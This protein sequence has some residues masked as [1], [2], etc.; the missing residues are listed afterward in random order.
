MTWEDSA[1][2]EYY[3]KIS[4]KF[5]KETADYLTFMEQRHKVATLDY[6]AKIEHDNKMKDSRIAHLEKILKENNIKE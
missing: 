2:K 6:I 1:Y 4:D 5:Q 3:A